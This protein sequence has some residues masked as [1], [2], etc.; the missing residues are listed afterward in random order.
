MAVQLSDIR[1][2]HWQ[3]QLGADGE[4]V[5]SL[6]DV[7]QAIRIVLTTPKGSDPHRPEFGADIWQYIDWPV[8]EAR[9]HVVREVRD[10]IDQWEPRAR[11]TSVAV[12][13]ANARLT[14]RIT[15]HL[16]ADTQ[17]TEETTEVA[18]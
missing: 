11:I 13:A 1:A 7:A 15:W 9:P 2:L 6:A 8:S 17:A 12:Q 16:T 18:L 4:V 10:A 3:P 14:V 5:E